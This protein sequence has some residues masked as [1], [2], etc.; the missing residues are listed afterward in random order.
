MKGVV[1]LGDSKVEVRDFPRPEPGLGQVVTE[2]KVAGLCG[3]DLHKYHSSQKW[4]RGRKGM[5][6]GH[7]PT[8]VVVEVGLNVEHIMSYN[9]Q[10]SINMLQELSRIYREFCIKTTLY[11]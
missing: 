10:Y 9:F 8:V 11:D 2:M 4:A 6:S 1:Y 5:I 7:E 3:S